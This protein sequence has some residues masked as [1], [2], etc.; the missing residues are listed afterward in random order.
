M[1]V[2]AVLLLL[3]ITIPLQASGDLRA[4]RKAFRP[5]RKPQEVHAERLAAL[6]GVAAVESEKLALVLVEAAEQLE[7][8][9]VPV[10]ERRLQ[11]LERSIKT[12]LTSRREIDSLRELQDRIDGK[13]AS[14]E[15]PKVVHTLVSRLIDGRKLPLTLRLRA[16]ACATRL[17]PGD[18]ADLAKGLAKPRRSVDDVLVVLQV[19]RALGAR[20]SDVAPSLVRY[21]E[22]DQAAVRLAAARTLAECASPAAIVPLIDRLKAERP[23]RA[24]QAIRDALQR[25]TGARIGAS[26]IAWRRWLEKEGGPYLRGEVPLS[27]G[28]VIAEE[29]A[30][31]G[32]T[33]HG[34]ALDGESIVFVLDRSKS[35]NQSMRGRGGK[36]EEGDQTR[37]ARARDELIR[38]LGVL[39]PTRRF[40]IVTFANTC[41]RFSEEMVP[42]TPE[43]VAAA[44]DWVRDIE[45]QLQTALYDGL[46]L[47]FLNAGLGPQ[48][49]FYAASVDTMFVL[50]DGQPIIGGKNDSKERIL[51]AVDRWNLL[52]QVRINVIGLGD[53]IPKRFLGKL[54]SRNGG[55]FIHEKSE[56][57]ESK[58]DDMRRESPRREPASSPAPRAADDDRPNIVL[59]Y[60]DDWG[61]TDGGFLGSAYYETPH[62]DRLAA[63]G[64]LFTD[65]YSAG[66]NC[67]PSRA[68]LM[69]GQYTPR[70]GVFTVGSPARG[71][72][73]N[74]KLIPVENRT[75]LR[76]DIVTL[77]EALREAGYATASV[78]KWH[79]G[80]DPR[81]QGFDVNAGGNATGSPR[82][83]HFSPYKN[84]QLADGPEGEYLTDRLTDEALAFIEGH[85]DE[86]FFLYFPHYAVHTPIQCKDEHEAKYAAKEPSAEH[87]NAKYAGMIESTDES[88]GRVLAK[89]EELGLARNTVVVLH[90]DNGGHGTV[91]SNAPLRGSKGMLYEGGI[92]VPLV[93][94]WPG[95]IEEGARC[96]VPVHGVDF[97]PTFL[98]LAGAS[99]PANQPLDGRSLV[100]LFDGAGKL[101]REAL[102]WHFPAYLEAYR[103]M[104]GPWRTTPAGAVRRGDLKLIEL[105]E[106]GRLELY[107]LAA[108]PGE[109][110]DLSGS[111]PEDACELHDLLR[112]WRRD[113]GAPVPTETNP[114]YVKPDNDEPRHTRTARDR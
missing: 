92:R 46:Q 12:G 86:P 50:T 22:H 84:G 81:T 23:G 103:G 36:A 19:S 38:A 90:S 61:W 78:G 113:V 72:S 104:E 35:M 110:H 67:A 49:V 66:P 51:A 42:A 17:A 89:L 93:L 109:A 79:L 31:S 7:K 5:A 16:A 55:E 48:D 105:F 54:A 69:S 87:R 77:A 100:P 59:F 34:L 53:S 108:D 95:R 2:A 15:E 101:D 26:V 88:L 45:L 83:D 106:D 114:E 73:K 58:S 29:R 18:L 96:S 24:R 76:E 11:N 99:P 13:L 9:S 43:N 40:N 37:L 52:D 4:L 10:E 71:K 65:A 75:D 98:E 97:Y 1:K 80:N 60:V 111:R 41:R 21:L 20:A 47:G 8:E 85:A 14:S 57:K 30:S 63:E 82:G 56:A 68:S 33:Y 70:H 28:E 91:T 44:Q 39:D 112:A 94:R 3:V 25:L 32:N 107:D 27:K 62:M 6:E 102:F 74:R 64:M